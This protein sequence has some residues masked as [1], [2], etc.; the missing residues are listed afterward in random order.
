M[1]KNI[2]IGSFLR[3]AI[4]SLIVWP[5]PVYALWWALNL[6]TQMRIKAMVY[7]HPQGKK[8]TETQII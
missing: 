3:V 6:G 1:E 7:S 2:S 5:A 4:Q 8:R